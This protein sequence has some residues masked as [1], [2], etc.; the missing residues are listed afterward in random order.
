M[1]HRSLPW[2]CV[3]AMLAASISIIHAQ[4]TA[5]AAGSHL[6]FLAIVQKQ[7][8]VPSGGETLHT[9]QATYYN[10][11]D[12]SGNC[13][14]DATPSD[15]MIAAMNHVDYAASAICGAYVEI[16]GPKGLVTVR[17]VDQCP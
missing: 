3:L 11:A 7:G 8:L 9:G 15:L 1:H 4:G 13:S 10:G 6:I 14:F 12:G 5:P 16:S 2:L 17:I